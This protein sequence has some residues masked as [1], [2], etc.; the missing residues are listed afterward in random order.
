MLATDVDGREL[1]A[2]T[3][4]VA[5]DADALRSILAQLAGE[6]DWDDYLAQQTRDESE[7]SAP[8]ARA[9]IEA[10]VA[11]DFATRPQFVVRGASPE[12]VLVGHPDAGATTGEQAVPPR[13]AAVRPDRLRSAAPRTVVDRLGQKYLGMPAYGWAIGIAIGTGAAV[14]LMRNKD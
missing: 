10:A 2:G 4:V 12:S 6:R 1:K 14:V 9:A 11:R 13:L 5:A 3:S 8:R 7:Q